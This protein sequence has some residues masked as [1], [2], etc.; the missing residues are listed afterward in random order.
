[1]KKALITTITMMLF[2][3]PAVAQV[4]TGV[5][6]TADSSSRS[7]TV[8]AGETYI[9]TAYDGFVSLNGSWLRL[10]TSLGNSGDTSQPVLNAKIYCGPGTTVAVTAGGSYASFA[11]LVK[12]VGP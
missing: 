3:L 2:S 9:L 12:I 10:P 6:L 7:F 4:G 1:M 11:T 8:P 5:T